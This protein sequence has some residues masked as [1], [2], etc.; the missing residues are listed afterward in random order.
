MCNVTA[1]VRIAQ[2]ELQ[3]YKPKSRREQKQEKMY[4]CA[5]KEL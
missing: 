2:Q 4:H 1:R 3:H 5:T